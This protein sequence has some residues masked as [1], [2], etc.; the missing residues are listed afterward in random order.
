MVNSSFPALRGLVNSSH[1]SDVHAA[2]PVGNLP[3]S[4]RLVIISSLVSLVIAVIGFKSAMITWSDP[5]E[6]E[7]IRESEERERI[8]E[9][10]CDKT[11]ERRADGS[12]S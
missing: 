6:I 11:S 3:T 1:T 7:T 9:L 10:L 5:T 12:T 2:Y 8:P 4:W